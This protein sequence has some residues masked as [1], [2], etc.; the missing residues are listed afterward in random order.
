MGPEGDE[1]VL[2]DPGLAPDHPG[3]RL[4]Q[5]VEAHDG[6]HAAH[7]LQAALD[8]VQEGGL[9]LGRVGGVQGR[10]GELR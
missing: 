1:P 4:A 3:H 6:E 7:E 5:V 2:L 9:G 8:P 10:G